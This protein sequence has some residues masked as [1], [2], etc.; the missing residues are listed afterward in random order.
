MTDIG[1]IIGDAQWLP[2][3]YDA[4]GDRVQFVHVTRQTHRE[5]TF[6]ANYQPDAAAPGTWLPGAA[7]RAATIQT[8]PV[9]WVFHTAFCRSTL[10]AKA[11]DIPGVAMGYS[12]PGVLNDLAEA[13]ARGAGQAMVR[14]IVDLLAR[15]LAPGEAV[16]LKPSNVVNRILPLVMDAR[17]D[18]RVLL[19]FGPLAGFLHSVQK[20]GMAGRRWARRLYLHVDG[21]APLDLGMG[22]AERFEFTDLQCAALAWLLQQRY[23]AILLHNKPAERLA[24]LDADRF[25][26]HRAATLAALGRFFR[27]PIDQPRAQAIATGPVFD[28]HAKFGDDFASRIE[29]ETEA[30]ASQVVEEEIAM[31]VQWTDAIANQIGVPIPVDKPL[32]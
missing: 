19:L 29:T 20:K 28:R 11:L 16:V 27:L 9:H 14:P 8:G 31:V 7:L 3:R 1:A 25:N 13:C 12:E 18:S 10:L 15:P 26:A 2:Y 30:A 4:A 6:L 21:Y 5:L 22:A 24:T 23:F 32:V 17:P